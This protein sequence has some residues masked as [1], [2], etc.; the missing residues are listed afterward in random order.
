[1]GGG[2]GAKAAQ[3]RERA[4]KDA[5]KDPQSQLKSVRIHSSFSTF[6][7]LNPIP[8]AGFVFYFLLVL[9]VDSLWR[10]TS[11]C[12]AESG[13]TSRGSFMPHTNR[14]NGHGHGHGCFRPFV[15]Y[16]LPLEGV[17]WL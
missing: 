16:I 1:M 13:A 6:E 9:P 8:V 17:W 2:N 12:L 7:S 5:K 3:K 15:G 10:L 14:E 11:A 4:A